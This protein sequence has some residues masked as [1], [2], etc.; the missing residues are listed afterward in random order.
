MC[1][2]RCADKE[3]LWQAGLVRLGLLVRALGARGALRAYAWPYMKN[4]TLATGT[5]VALRAYA[6]PYMKNLTLATGTD[7]L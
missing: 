7:V 1:L 5:D 2:F 3:M 6:W 4:L